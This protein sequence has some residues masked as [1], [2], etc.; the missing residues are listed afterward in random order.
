MAK[1]DLDY[2]PFLKTLQDEA[3]KL[4][5][6]ALEN[7]CKQLDQIAD[8]AKVIMKKLHREFKQSGKNLDSQLLRVHEHTLEMI[9]SLIRE[10]QKFILSIWDNIKLKILGLFGIVTFDTDSSNSNSKTEEFTNF[11]SKKM[12]E[13]NERVREYANEI[14]SGQVQF[15]NNMK[16]KLVTK[17]E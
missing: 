14:I 11:M 7:A 2:N 15:Y 10:T 4:F 5:E 17:S 16:A 1:N 12:K 13:F 9:A 6:L 3:L 8:Q